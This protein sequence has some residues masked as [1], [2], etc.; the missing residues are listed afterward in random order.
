MRYGYVSNSSSSSFVLPKKLM[1]DEDI[2][3]FHERNS[4][5]NDE[6]YEENSIN[7]TTNYFFGKASMHDIKL[8]EI[9]Y[10]YKQSSYSEVDYES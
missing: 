9:I 10:N 4:W 6:I 1:S 5:M 8:R 7:E 3:F 2:N